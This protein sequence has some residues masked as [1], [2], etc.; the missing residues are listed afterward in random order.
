M[1]DVLEALPW[2]ISTTAVLAALVMLCLSGAK[3]RPAGSGPTL[4]RA[5][6][7]AAQTRREVQKAT[8]ANLAR[9]AAALEGDDPEGDIA[10]LV[11]EADGEGG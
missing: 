4:R 7:D 10:G 5:R 11:D 1:A 2:I 6:V 8:R 3:R 9:I